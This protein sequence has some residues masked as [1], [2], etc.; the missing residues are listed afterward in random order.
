MHVC[1]NRPEPIDLVVEG[2]RYRLCTARWPQYGRWQIIAERIL[3]DGRVGG[4]HVLADA[5]DN[6]DLTELWSAGWPMHPRQSA[7]PIARALVAL[8]P[9]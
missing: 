2:Q 9:A 7:W 1:P 3:P 6:A 4:F 8:G 5:R